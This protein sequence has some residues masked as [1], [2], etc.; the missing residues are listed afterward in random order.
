MRLCIHVTLSQDCFVVLLR[1]FPRVFLVSLNFFISCCER[2]NFLFV[3]GYHHFVTPGRRV[4]F[5]VA[6]FCH[7]AV[8]L[9]YICSSVSL[10][11]ALYGQFFGFVSGIFKASFCIVFA[12]FWLFYSHCVFLWSFSFVFVP[13]SVK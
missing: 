12:T 4:V 11:F 10:F 9:V 13:F 5:V 2:S 1:S 6:F 7:F 3:F 8:F